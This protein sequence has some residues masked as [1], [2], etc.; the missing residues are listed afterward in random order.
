[1]EFIAEVGHWKHRRPLL[2]PILPS[3]LYQTGFEE[4]QIPMQTL[5]GD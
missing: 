1:M 3:P 5:K 2:V 4:A